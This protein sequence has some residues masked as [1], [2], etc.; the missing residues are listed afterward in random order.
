MTLSKE[1]I[2]SA[3]ESAEPNRKIVDVSELGGSV[4]VREM[5][6]T[7][8]NAFEAAV[9]GLQGSDG[10][11]R[12]TAVTVRIVSECTL[13]DE[14]N[15]L[16]DADRTRRLFHRKPRAVFRLRDEIIALSAMDESDLEA[17]VEGFGEAQ[18]DEPGF[19]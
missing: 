2:D 3:I 12:L 7:L 15:R 13:D 8:R 5:S 10:E 14:G 11:K 6:G 19:D 17:M 1:Q 4:V 18:S 9:A 16:L